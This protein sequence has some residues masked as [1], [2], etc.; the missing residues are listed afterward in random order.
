MPFS[1]GILLGLL[2]AILGVIMLF[3]SKNKKISLAVILI[4]LAF[5]LFTL[6]VIIFMA[7]S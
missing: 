7:S 6:L 3:I 5:T 4:G 1:Y 2:V